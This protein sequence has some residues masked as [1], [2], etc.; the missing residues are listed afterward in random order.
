[1]MKIPVL[2]VFAVLPV[3]H[4]EEG[5]ETAPAAAPAAAEEKLS[6][7]E[8]RKKL[9]TTAKEEL[10]V[11]NKT[12]GRHPYHLESF[13]EV[14]GQQ[15]PESFR[16][17][18]ADANFLQ[19]SFPAEPGFEKSKE[20]AKAYVAQL[21][22]ESRDLRRKYEAE[23][24]KAVADLVK[25]AAATQDPEKL[26]QMGEELDEFY[27]KMVSSRRQFDDQGGYRIA[28][29]CQDQSSIRNFISQIG[30][31]HSQRV[32]EQWGSAASNLQELRRQAIKLNR[33]LP[34][35]EA[36]AFIASCERSIGLL[37]L[38]ETSQLFD[39][40]VGELLDDKNQDRLD[41]IQGTIRKQVELCR[42]SSKSAFS[43]KWQNLSELASSFSQNVSR[44]KQGSPPQFSAEQW[45]RSNPDALVSIGR[46]RLVEAMKRYRV[47]VK[48]S[49]GEIREEPIYYDMNEVIARIQSP[50][51]IAR[52]MP[53]FQKASKQAS[54]SSDNGNWQTLGQRLQ[55]YGELFAKLESGASFAIG[56]YGQSEYGYERSN[57]PVV[58]DAASKK[59]AELNQQLQWMIVQRFLPDVQVDAKTTPAKAVADRFAQAKKGGDYQAMLT[60]GR[61]S[62]Y[63]APGQGLLTPQDG[64]AIQWYLDGVKQEEQLGQPR[65][66]T[67]Y[68]QRSA[69]VPNSP[70]PPHVFKARLKNLKYSA[71]KDYDKGTDDALG[72]NLDST[73]MGMQAPLMVPEKVTAEEVPSVK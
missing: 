71:P 34:V 16:A 62:A 30:R 60:L 10:E 56:A 21:T 20:L 52:E 59:A 1:M 40:T 5:K 37:P 19:T 26:A 33:Y 32:E 50:A 7:E 73:G 23:C 35:N 13:F 24:T 64:L 61:L 11:Y 72:R 6:A 39:A 48:D 25:R 51:D 44:M 29:I 70:I 66:A 67:Y 17:E 54:Y 46:E 53:V 27:R 68:F 38:E 41:A 42:S 47:K 2:F 8:L 14:L 45:V 9:V 22:K 36:M 57:N 58:E 49:T 65:L 15:S 55:Q 63:L 4:A 12:E 31:F 28:E 69:A 18:S 43:Q 3:L